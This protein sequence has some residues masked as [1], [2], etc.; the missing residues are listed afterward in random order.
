MDDG[1][2]YVHISIE[3]PQSKAMWINL[4]EKQLRCV[5]YVKIYHRVKQITA[6]ECLSE[7]DRWQ[8]LQMLYSNVESG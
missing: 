1:G 2:N 6:R 4:V 5:Y 8:E 7:A 3:L